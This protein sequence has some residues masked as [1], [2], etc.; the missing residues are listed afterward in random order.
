MEIK[1]KENRAFRYGDGLFETIIFKNKELQFWN[2]HLERLKKG[3]EILH[4]NANLL[5][6]ND[7]LKIK[8]L[9]KIE[10][11]SEN[12]KIRINIWRKDGGLYTPKTNEIDFKINIFDFEPQIEIENIE[13][14]ISKNV[15][16]NYSAISMLKTTN[17]LLYVLA[18]IEKNE[19][20]IADILLLDNHGN[21]SEGNMSNIFWEKSGIVY[22]P[23]LRCGCILGVRRANILNILKENQVQVIEGEFPV[24]NL[25]NADG[26]ILTNVA[27]IKIINAIEGK[28]IHSKFDKLQYFLKLD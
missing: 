19:R 22:T 24:D 3:C 5:F 25:Y 2:L 15:F 11:I 26:I 6:E 28:N 18:G 17:S 20:K 27:G 4:F 23:S 8:V 14:G 13:V 12:K 7:F 21:I 1:T 9:E 10:Y 16:L